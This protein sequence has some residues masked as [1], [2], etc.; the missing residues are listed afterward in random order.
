MENEYKG[1]S[2]KIAIIGLIGI[3]TFWV[4]LGFGPFFYFE[5]YEISGL[6]GDTFGAVNSLFSAFAFAG[7]VY[8]IFLQRDELKLQR[9]ELEE[10]RKELA[11][12]ATAQEESQ[13]A[14]KAQLSSMYQTSK[15]NALNSLIQANDLLMAR[16]TLGPMDFENC[17]N[18]MFRYSR[19]LENLLSDIDHDK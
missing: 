4:F 19:Q 5:K 6:F 8:T 9:L 13:A 18:K 16:G 12:S 2:N 17:K 3:T 11:R 1:I 10:T 15:I 14:L 7:L